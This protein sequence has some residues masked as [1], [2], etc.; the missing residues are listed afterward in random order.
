M[1]TEEAAI[2][3]IGYSDRDR[4]EEKGRESLRERWGAGYGWY[5]MMH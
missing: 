1:G 3:V 5:R 4:D 2:P